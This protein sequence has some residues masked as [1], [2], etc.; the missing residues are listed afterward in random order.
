MSAPMTLYL[1]DG[2]LRVAITV[3]GE[4]PGLVVFALPECACRRGG[5]GGRT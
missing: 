2:K 4:M 3:G 5:A 1:L